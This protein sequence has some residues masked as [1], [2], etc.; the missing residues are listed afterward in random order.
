M[1]CFLFALPQHIAA[2]GYNS[3][4]ILID[5]NQMTANEAMQ[6]SKFSADGMWG[7][8]SNNPTVP[9]TIKIGNVSYGQY[10]INPTSSI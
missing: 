2:D 5:T 10:I 4:R 8:I 9:V 3:F 1:I 7:L 6:A